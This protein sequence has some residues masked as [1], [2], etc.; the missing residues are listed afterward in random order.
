MWV[1]ISSII[2][3]SYGGGNLLLLYLNMVT[4]LFIVLIYPAMST[5]VWQ[6]MLPIQPGSFWDP[7]LNLQI[8]PSSSQIPTYP[9]T[10]QKY[11]IHMSQPLRP[12]PTVSGSPHIPVSQTIQG[13]S[14]S[15]SLAQGTPQVSIGQILQ[16]LAYSHSNS[17]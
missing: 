12:I 17:Y 2:P 6:P 3:S 15:P 14:P 7:L 8:V 1:S 9:S 13:S 16:N 10:P 11:Q 4:H 5:S